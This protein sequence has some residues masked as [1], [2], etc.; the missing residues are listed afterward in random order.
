MRYFS[1]FSLSIA[2]C[3]AYLVVGVKLNYLIEMVCYFLL[4]SLP[5]F[6]PTRTLEPC[7][8]ADGH[9][10]LLPFSL[11]QKRRE[12]RRRKRQKFSLFR[13]LSFLKQIFHCKSYLGWN[14]WVQ[15]NANRR[16]W[17]AAHFKLQ[18]QHIFP[19]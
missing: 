3:K 8:L 4:Q 1:V 2:Y 13:S 5:F 6:S 12:R 15:K 9:T 19:G 7:F 17:R 11:P 14:V 16:E 18:E 10:L